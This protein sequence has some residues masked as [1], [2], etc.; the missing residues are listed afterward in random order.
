MI[1]SSYHVEKSETAIRCFLC[2][3]VLDLLFHMLLTLRSV[4]ERPS[5][6]PLDGP[7][8]MLYII[9]EQFQFNICFLLS[10][11]RFLHEQLTLEHHVCHLYSHLRARSILLPPSVQPPRRRHHNRVS[12]PFTKF[13]H[14][15][16]TNY[17]FP[18]QIHVD[19]KIAAP[20]VC[21][22]LS[23]SQTISRQYQIRFIS[24]LRITSTWN[25]PYTHINN[26]V[27]IHLN[28]HNSSGTLALTRPSSPSLSIR[29]CYCPHVTIAVYT[30]LDF[31]L[32]QW[33]SPN[34]HDVLPMFSCNSEQD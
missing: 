23:S 13:A 16:A 29:Q 31:N 26:M 5:S 4:T 2:P 14:L 27:A 10:N 12:I 24:L 33:S 20:L 1:S 19:T 18:G 25:M 34:S 15:I 7:F 11:L 9:T 17:I 22:L 21:R 28:S 6:Q 8:L 30:S 32:S 3:C